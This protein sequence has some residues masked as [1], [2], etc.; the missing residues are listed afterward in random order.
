ML[1][2]LPARRELAEEIVVLDY[3]R[4]THQLLRRHVDEVCALQKELP[5]SMLYLTEMQ[6]EGKGRRGPGWW[7]G[8]CC[9]NLAASLLLKNPTQ[10]PETIGLHAACAVADALSPLLQ[11]PQDLA[12]KWPNDVHLA[13]AKVGGVL[14]EVS[15]R[16][17]QQFAM[18]GVGL[19]LLQ[20]PPEDVATYRTTA[21]VDHGIEPDPEE[22]CQPP[23]RGID[24]TRLVAAWVWALEKRLRWARLNGHQ[25]LERD[26]LQYLRRWAPHG[27]LDP[28][29][30]HGGPLVEFS[31]QRG[32]TWGEKGN[33]DTRP[34]G[35]IPSLD[36]IEKP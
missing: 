2:L 23:S 8:S 18:V 4:S 14:V 15:E 12:L 6:L 19:N 3:C 9:Q 5:P 21:V 32:L 1:R 10:P 36:A 20:A 30:G 27:V 26:F 34:L 31:V 25:Q 13:G 33:T 7:S 24:R 11:Q 22:V 28:A 35:W 16:H 29:T 17:G